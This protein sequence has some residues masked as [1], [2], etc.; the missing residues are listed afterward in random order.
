M[1]QHCVRPWYIKI[2]SESLR[3]LRIIQWRGWIDSGPHSN[4]LLVGCGNG[5]KRPKRAHIKGAV[6]HTPFLS[7]I[8]SCF[9]LQLYKLPFH[10]RMV[11]TEFYLSSHLPVSKHRHL[12]GLT[13]ANT[14][15]R[16][17][18]EEFWWLTDEEPTLKCL[19]VGYIFRTRP[20]HFDRIL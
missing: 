16:I 1:H 8:L 2:N 7:P 17:G 12:T 10:C 15:I 4:I 11:S 18:R 6:R 3:S 19:E 5:S 13:E 14:Q 9:P 20:D